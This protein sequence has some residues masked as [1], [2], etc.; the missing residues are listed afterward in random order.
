[1]AYSRNRLPLFHPD[2]R[3]ALPVSMTEEEFARHFPRESAYIE[4]KAGVGGRAIQRTATAFSNSDGGIIL[5]GV[6]DGGEVIGKS[7]TPGVETVITQALLEVHDPGRFWLHEVSVDDIPVTVLAVAR[8]THGFAQTSDGQVMVRHG[9]HTAPLLGAELLQFLGERQLTRF[10]STAAHIPVEDI[11]E[12]AVDSVKRAYGWR[13]VSTERLRNEGLV[14][15]DDD[16]AEL[17]VAGVLTL[18]AEPEDVLGKSFV[19]VLRYPDEGVDY[20]RRIEITGPVQ[21]QVA[22]ATEEVMDELGTDLVISG[23]RRLELPKLPRVVVREAVANAVAHRSYEEHGRAIR[24]ELRPDR[25]VIQSPGGLPEPVTEENIRETQFARNI[26]VIKVL[27]RVGLAEDSGRGVDVMIDSMA[28]ALLDPP[29][30]RDQGHSVEVVLPVRGAISPQERAWI[31]EIEQRGVIGPRD[32][33]VL[34]HAARGEELTNEDVREMLGVDSR[35]ARAALRRLRDAGFLEQLGERGGS[36][37]VLAESVG[38]PLA[39]RMSPQALRRLVLSLAEDGPITNTSVREATGL[40][41]T[42]ALRLLEALVREGKIVRRG[43]RR[44]SYY[45][46][47]SQRLPS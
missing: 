45:L 29:T 12:D 30:F 35:D 21:D 2:S 42:E 20:N 34:V 28:E 36:R 25:V 33:L 9:A 17:T 16:V 14:I 3:A 5:F 11:D 1:M 13:R 18:T 26:N 10:D 32:R 41:R 19:E 43:E 27:R 40:D 31:L 46:L 8:R 47:A 44:G 7:L 22:R 4:F 24:I 38:A 15:G 39:L 6:T 23:I 37:Y